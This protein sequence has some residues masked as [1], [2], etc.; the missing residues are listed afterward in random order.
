MRHVQPAAIHVQRQRPLLGESH[1]LPHLI[2]IVLQ[3]LG[4]WWAAPIIK[5]FIPSLPRF[6]GYNVDVFIWAILFAFI[7]FIIGF[8]GSI[9]LKGVRTPGAGSLTLALVLAL[10]IAALTLVPQITQAASGAGVRVDTLWW[11]LLGAMAGYF[12]K[13]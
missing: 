8:V 13:R 12:I 5:S 3:I 1:M 6:G 7:V 2:L 11:P 10:I 9:V 4:A